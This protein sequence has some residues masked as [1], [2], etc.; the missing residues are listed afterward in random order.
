MNALALG[1][2]DC[3]AGSLDV[4]LDGP[5]QTADHGVFHHLGDFIHRFEV[6]G[7]GDGETGL[8]HVHA[9]LIENFSHTQLFLEIHRAA[10]RLFAVAQGRIKDDDTFVLIGICCGHSV[11]LLKRFCVFGNFGF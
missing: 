9:H 3:H 7:R 6:A 5:R 4:A 1:W 11:L 8:D 2:L 10:G